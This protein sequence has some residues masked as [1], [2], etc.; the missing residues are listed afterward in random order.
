MADALKNADEIKADAMKAL[1][2]SSTPPAPTNGEPAAPPAE[3]VAESAAPAATKEPDA[4]NPASDTPPANEPKEGD[5]DWKVPG[6][7]LQDEV[8]KRKEAEAK[9]EAAE[10]AR[11]EAEA[12][13]EAANKPKDP[14]NE[15]E[16]DDEGDEVILRPE[17]K[18][19]LEKEGYVSKDKVSEIVRQEIAAD[20]KAA[21]SAAQAKADVANL[22]DWA[23]EK[24]YPEFKVEDVLPKAKEM[25]GENLSKS[26]LKA[27]YMEKYADDIENV[28]VKQAQASATAPTA[29]AERPGGSPGVKAADDPNKSG[30]QRTL[31]KIGAVV[32]ELG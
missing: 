11:K 14:E 13:L 23:K 5:K 12:K 30:K 6:E 1:G 7:R 8:K 32:D 9:A 20:R 28:L 3:P 18:K 31:E 16:P 26:A 19:A 25:F 22:S 29:S 17:T 15:P 2:D 24:G 21:E 27:A 10:T 4:P